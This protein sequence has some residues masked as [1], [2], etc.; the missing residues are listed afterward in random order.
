MKRKLSS[1]TNLANKKR[2]PI[3]HQDAISGNFNWPDGSPIDTNHMLISLMLP[4]AVK[5]FF[6]E[7]N[8]EVE[9]LCGKRSL[10]DGGDGHRWGKQNGSVFFANQRVAI[11]R[12]RLRSKS[13]G[14]EIV[15]DAYAKFQNPQL[16]EESVFV[17]GMKHVSQRDFE[18]GLPLVASSFGVS[19]S[20]IS[21]RWIKATAKKLDELMER[22]ISAMDIVAIFIDG[23]RFR[24]HG[25]VVALGVSS[26]GKKFVLGIFEANTETG[27]AVM[28]LLD[29]LERRGLPRGKLLFIV[30]GGSGLNSC[31]NRKYSID[32]PKKRTA[33][34]VR[35]WIHR[36]WNIKD[37]LRTEDIADCERL[38]WAIR[39]ATSLAEAK[40]ASSAFKAHLGLLNKSA[41]KA[42][43]ETEDE[44]LVIHELN[45]NYELKKVL[46][47]TNPIESL[48]SLTEEDTR[49]VKSWKNSEHF[50]RWLATAC[51]HNEKRMKR[52]KGY[53]GL[54]ALKI[55][56]SSM[57]ASIEGVDNEA[58]IA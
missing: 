46:S 51:L 50:Q 12:P 21:R 16:F 44:L 28:N 41:R 52:V 29:N 7:L 9:A 10:H 24:S 11:E 13:T 1:V 27:A 17:E 6:E 57:C 48:N 49:R 31:L 42:F 30:D 40:A 32:D 37:L 54:A 35:C 43:E 25:V 4:P 56:L 34:R 23:K 8:Q 58:R 47:T 39:G 36:W 19:K 55:A 38:Y 14:R 45:L 2:I 53:R 26:T 5:A 20:A 33:V 15:P 3:T 18:K 22:D